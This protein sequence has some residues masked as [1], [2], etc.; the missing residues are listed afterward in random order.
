MK[1][2]WDINY[3]Y[4]C[5]LRHNDPQLC[6]VWGANYKNKI[7]YGIRSHHMIVTTMRHKKIIKGLFVK[8]SFL[9][10]WAWVVVCSPAKVFEVNQSLE[11]NI[12]KGTQYTINFFIVHMA[13]NCCI[14]AL[15][16]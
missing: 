3:S 14:A 2:Q 5:V 1:D 7:S 9:E 6:A 10:K 15:K 12:L 8:F 13:K 16:F 4:N 11:I